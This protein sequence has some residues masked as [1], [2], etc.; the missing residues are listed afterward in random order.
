M[1]LQVDDRAR[2]HPAGSSPTGPTGPRRRSRLPRRLRRNRSILVA[3]VLV[4]LIVTSVVAGSGSG[5]PPPIAPAPAHDNA[6]GAFAGYEN[7][8]GIRE[9]STVIH[10]PVHQAMD[11]FDGSTWNTIV[12]SP[13]QIVPVWNRSGYQMTW[14]VPMLP[15]SG[16][17]LTTG[18]TGAYD[19]YFAD[20]AAYLVAHGQ[21]SSIIRLG[22][23]FNGNWF[24]WAA[25]TC[26]QCFVDY[27]RKIVTTMRAVPG[28][29]F[30][31]EWN[32]DLGTYYLPPTSAYPGDR[33][34]D[35]VAL[36]VYDDVPGAAVTSTVPTP[37]QRW[38]LLVENPYG[39]TWVTGFA[40]THGKSVAFPEWG[41]GYGEN[42]GGDD[43]YFV[44][45]MASFITSNPDVVSALY[46]NY[47]NSTL[48][49]SPL[50]SSAFAAS[51][52][53]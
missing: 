11:F 9:V 3:L 15:K 33:Y 44:T 4:A 24:P 42:A 7:V 50:A 13:A 39:L 16:A 37:E 27:F 20:V 28:N 32:P 52:G 17:S 47:G 5:P 22:W 31:F 34:V 35:I 10:K 19:H 23:E 1:G 6:L 53:R 43:P 8:A 45:Q 30:L 48:A 51:F 12:K 18:A 21:A 29:H 38:N 36:D 14:G 2:L 40:A 25:A 49:S 46:W 41:L 26:A